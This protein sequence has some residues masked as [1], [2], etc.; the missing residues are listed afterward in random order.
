MRADSS[1][2]QCKFCQTPIGERE[3]HCDEECH[4][5]HLLYKQWKTTQLCTKLPFERKEETEETFHDII[6]RTGGYPVHCAHRGG[7]FEF[8]PENTLYGFKK[9]V[10][11]GARILELDLRLTKDH[12]LVLMHWSTVDETTDGKGVIS[13]MTLT[14]IKRLDAAAHHP[15]LKGKGISVPTLE[16]FLDLFV[17]MKDVLFFLDF[18]DVLTFKTTMRVIARYD[19]SNR[20]MLGSCMRA[21]NQLALK[22]KY[23]RNMKIP[24][25]TDILQ[26]FEITTAYMTNF[27]GAYHFEHDIFGFVLCRATTPFWSRGLV[28]AIHSRGRRIAVSSFGQELNKPER[29]AEAISFG[30]DFIMTDRPDLLQPLLLPMAK[31]AAPDVGV[32]ML[33]RQSG[34][35]KK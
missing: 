13:E 14:E 10:E 3:T 2:P 35:Q 15:L 26:S 24:V 9:S 30:V 33:Q 4:N 6:M 7:G 20:Y 32:M 17:P 28:D 19:M 31:E 29:L 27:L 18:K 11:H 25:C 8:A 1:Q 5:E 23:E 22:E 21:T 12:H 16:E 34:R